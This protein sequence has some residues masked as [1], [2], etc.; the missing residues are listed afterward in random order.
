[1]FVFDPANHK[2][3]INER[4]GCNFLSMAQCKTAIHYIVV[5]PAY[6]LLTNP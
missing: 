2:L 4:P 1:M 6:G 3:K 5:S